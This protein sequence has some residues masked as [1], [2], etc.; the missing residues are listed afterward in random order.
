MITKNAPMKERIEQAELDDYI[1]E[2]IHLTSDNPSHF[3]PFTFSLG[4]SG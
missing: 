3:S 4:S 2:V 1:S